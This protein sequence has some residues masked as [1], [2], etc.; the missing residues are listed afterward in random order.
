MMNFPFGTNGKFSIFRC[1]NLSTLGYFMAT[2][3]IMAIDILHV[4]VP[5]EHLSIE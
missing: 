4:S 1:P 3:S 2:S 5:A